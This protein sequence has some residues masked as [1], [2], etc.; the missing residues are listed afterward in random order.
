MAAVLQVSEVSVILVKG[1]SISITHTDK[2]EFVCLFVW[3][4]P[5]SLANVPTL[6]KDLRP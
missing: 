5:P 2:V 3:S 4:N 6:V 1:G